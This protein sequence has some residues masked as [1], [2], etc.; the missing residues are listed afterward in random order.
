MNRF[1]FQDYQLLKENF[2]APDNINKEDFSKDPAAWVEEHGD[3]L[4]RIALSRVRNRELAEDMVQETMLA[5]MKSIDSFSGK[6]TLRT[7]LASIL[8]HKII[9]HFRKA[10]REA[11]LKEAEDLEFLVENSFEKNGHWKTGPAKWAIDPHEILDRS[12]FWEFYEKCLKDLPQS[13]AAAFTMR[14]MDGL[15][16]GEICKVLDISSSN[17]WVM[18]HRARLGLREC[19]ERTLFAK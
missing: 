4:F 2:L 12:E 3:Y 5:A 17:L 7:W 8:K 1:C 13:H 9:D 10:S 6:S 16:S 19:L 18:L 11:T 14:E 15:D